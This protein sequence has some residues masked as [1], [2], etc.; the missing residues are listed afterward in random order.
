MRVRNSQFL[1]II[2]FAGG[3]LYG[4]MRSQQRL[5]GLEPNAAEIRRYGAMSEEELKKR[6]LFVDEPNKNLI[7]NSQRH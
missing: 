7:D 1:G 5:M 6:I 2:G 3:M 4:A